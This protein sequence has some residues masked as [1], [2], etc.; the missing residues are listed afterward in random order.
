MQCGTMLI[1]AQRQAGQGKSR[2]SRV[3]SH[4]LL[5]ADLFLHSAVDL[6][7]LNTFR[8][9]GSGSRLIL[10]KVGGVEARIKDLRAS[11]AGDR[12]RT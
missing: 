1:R 5:T 9:E 2:Y 7:E 8:L 12:T 3:A 4:F 10:S 11:A 6:C